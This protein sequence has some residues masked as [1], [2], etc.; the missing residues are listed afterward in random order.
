MKQIGF[1]PAVASRL[2][3]GKVDSLRLYQTN[4]LCTHLNCTP[5]D[6]IEYVPS[7]NESLPVNH[8]L[9]KLVRNDKPF[10]LVGEVSHLTVDQV[11][12]VEQFISKIKEDGEGN[13]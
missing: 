11:K 6:L 4:I 1:S 7:A 3:N 2:L 13:G 5:N 10:N 12:E 8:A 9:Q